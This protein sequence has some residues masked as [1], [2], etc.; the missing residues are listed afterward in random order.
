MAGHGVGR[1]EQRGAPLDIDT[2]QSISIVAGPELVEVRQQSVVGATTTR[3]TVLNDYVRIFLS[4]ALQ[5][6]EQSKMIVDIEVRLFLHR[7]VQ[8]TDILDRGISIPLQ[9]GNLG[10]FG[11]QVVNYPEGKVL[12]FWIGHIQHQ[13]RTATTQFQFATFGL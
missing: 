6:F 11:Q 2:L 9:I 12:H 10:I 8:R 1:E 4:D 7:Q 13:L 5:H 3:G